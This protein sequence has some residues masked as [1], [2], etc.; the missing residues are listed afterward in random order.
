[1]SELVLRPSD[2]PANFQLQMEMARAY[3]TAD[4]LPGHLRRKPEN[5]LIILGAARAL[6]IPAFWAIQ[7]LFVVGGKLGMEASLMRAL[8]IRAGHQFET[9]KMSRDEAIVAIK[10]SDKSSWFEVSFDMTDAKLAKLSGDNWIKYPRSML[11]A[12]ATV[13]A[14]RA[15]CPE[16]LYGVLYTPEE[17]GAKVDEEGHPVLDSTNGMVIL[18]STAEEVVTIDPGTWEKIVTDVTTSELGEAANSYLLATRLRH[19]IP[20]DAM[21]TLLDAWHE[22]LSTEAYREDATAE[23]MRALWKIA[24]GTGCLQIDM[25]WRDDGQAVRSLPLSDF[26]SARVEAIAHMHPVDEINE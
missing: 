8:V 17:L 5:V 2:V 7:S 25:R 10:R 13:M 9:R 4:L 19:T 6:N 20:A 3:A 23:D 22:R 24:N 11:H 14:I 18:D 21:T 1:L 15:E 26:I 12:R 16:V